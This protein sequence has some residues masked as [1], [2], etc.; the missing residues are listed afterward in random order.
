M[1][2]NPFLKKTKEKDT[3]FQGQHENPNIKLKL[4]PEIIY[5]IGPIC[6]RR[7]VPLCIDWMP[8]GKRVEQTRSKEE[9]ETMGVTTLAAARSNTT[10]GMGFKHAVAFSSLFK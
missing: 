10:N 4:N 7:K 6:S 2:S 3:S 9:K 1:V 8:L 5:L